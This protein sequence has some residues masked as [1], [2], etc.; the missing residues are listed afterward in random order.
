VPR[1]AAYRRPTH[2]VDEDD[3]GTAERRRPEVEPAAGPWHATSAASPY[4][5]IERAVSRISAPG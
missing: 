3:D 2:R 1:A 4:P 5:A